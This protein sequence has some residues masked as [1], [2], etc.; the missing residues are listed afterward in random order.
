MKGNNMGA[1]VQRAKILKLNLFQTW[2]AV[3]VAIAGLGGSA[4]AVASGWAGS[5]FGLP[6]KVKEIQSTQPA[7]SNMLWRV[8]SLETTQKLMWQK[9]TVDHDLLIKIDQKLTDQAEQ[10]Q[11][12]RMDVKNLRK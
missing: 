11:E 7:I 9:L 12:L 6:E 8:D 1:D 2:L 10:T 4:Y 5:W 3:I